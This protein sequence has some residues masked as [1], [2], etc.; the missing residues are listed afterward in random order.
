MLQR[1]RI[2]VTATDL[3]VV[4]NT[5]ELTIGGSLGVPYF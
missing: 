3:P 4:A 2:G 5:L 1:L